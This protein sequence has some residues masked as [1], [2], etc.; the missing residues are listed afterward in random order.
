MQLC[1]SKAKS[2]LGTHCGTWK[3]QL[4]H[5]L[6]YVAATLGK[7]YPIRPRLE[8]LDRVRQ[9]I[10]RVVLDVFALFSSP[11]CKPKICMTC[12][13]IDSG[14]LYECVTHASRSC[15]GCYKRVDTIQHV[16]SLFGGIVAASVLAKSL[17]L[18][19]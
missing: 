5:P 14:Y 3:P 18:S 7:D 10:A 6:F 19:R 17:A 15:Y 4:L 16:K 11:H 1:R 2:I 12:F 13:G 8:I 9:K